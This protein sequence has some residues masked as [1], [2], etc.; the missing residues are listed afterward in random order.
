[1]TAHVIT[2]L[3]EG[4]PARQYRCPETS[5]VL[6]GMAQQACDGVQVGCRSGGCGV[7]RVEILSG[8]WTAKKMSKAHVTEADLARNIV[9]ACRTFATS[10]LTLRPCPRGP[11]VLT[12]TEINDKGE[13]E[14]Q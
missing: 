6:E 4:E 2:V 14:W 7:C 1:V 9:L 5:S 11:A 10:D 3:V 8:A 13:Q 12:P